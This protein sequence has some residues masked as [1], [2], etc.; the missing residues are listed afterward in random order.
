MAR[1]TRRRLRWSWT[2]WSAACSSRSRFLDLLQHFIVFEED[3]DSERAAQ[4]HRRLPPVPRGKC[5]GGGNG[6]GQRHGRR[7][8]DRPTEQADKPGDRRAGVVWHTQ[9]S[10]KSFSMLFYAARIVR[11]PAMQNPTL[12]VLTD[13]NDLDDQLFG[14]FQRCHE[15]LGQT[16]VQA[17]DREQLRELLK[18][19][20]GGV[21]FTTIQKFMPEKGE[22]MPALSPRRNIVVIAD[23]AHRSQYDL[24]DGLGPQSAGCA[25]E[26]LVHRLHRHAHREERRQ[27][28]GDLRRLHLA[29]TTS[30]APWPTSATVPIYYES[31]IAKL[32]LNQ[33]AELPKIDEEFD[34]ITEGEEDAKK[35]KLKTKWAALEALVGD[36]KRIALI[37]ADLVQHFETPSGSDGRQ[38][39]GRLHEPAHLRGPLQRDHQ[40]APGWASA[41][42]D[43]TEA[44]KKQA[45]V[46]KIVMTGSAEDGPDW[47]PHIRNKDKRRESGQCASRTA[48]TRS[49]S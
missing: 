10:G 43:D 4:D 1:G 47:Q 29:S 5:G 11:H 27:H 28:A 36:P 15:L 42:D 22:K 13:R 16:P 3:P 30:S 39:D 23:E 14:Q 7:A 34:E 40:A 8:R 33:A 2:C 18:V 21:V 24:I 25:A 6:A 9:G 38:G 44:E 48:R 17:E 12:V 49:A 46:V 31:R 37:A 20:S 19:A 26:R 45:C 32:A 35:Q 41:K